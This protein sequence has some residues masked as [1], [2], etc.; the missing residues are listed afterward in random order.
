MNCI[1]QIYCSNLNRPKEFA[2]S[3]LSICPTGHGGHSLIARGLYALH[4]EPWLDAFLDNIKVFTLEDLQGCNI[5]GTMACIYEYIGL[6]PHVVDDH[7]V[8]TVDE[9]IFCIISCV[10][11]PYLSFILPYSLYRNHTIAETTH[12]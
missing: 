7:K 2:K 11:K 8:Q 5:N 4:L 12:L 9:S 6:P 3:W 10:L 1:V